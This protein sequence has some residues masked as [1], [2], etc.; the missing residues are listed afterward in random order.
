MG[1]VYKAQDL[2][3]HRT[4]ALKLLPSDLHA[5]ERAR[6]L[7]LQEA[8]S[9]SA[10]DH[11]NIGTIHAIE[12]AA[13]GSLF[14]VMAYYDGET[15]AARIASGP[16]PAAQ[17]VE[18]AIQ[19]A[20]G[21]AEAHAHN[22]VHRD[23]K[24]GNA[25][26]TRQGLT[27][28][29][30]FGLARVIES[31]ESTVSASISGT[32]AYMSP[33]QAQGKALDHRT[34]LWSLGVVLYEMLTGRL[35]FKGETLPARLYSIVHSAPAA[36]DEAPLE[37]QAIVYRALAKD[38]A[39]RYPTAKEM[40][41]DLE[42]AGAAASVLPA[43][44]RAPDNLRRY[45]ASASGSALAASQ[46]PRPFAWRWMALVAVTLL[47]AFGVVL[48]AFRDRAFT[49]LF[50][51]AA[52]HIAVLPLT[53][54][55]G[56]APNAAIADGLMESLTSKLSNLDVGSRSLWVVPASEVRR[57]RVED[58]AAARREFGAT[59]V[60][61]GS[62]QRQENALRLIVNLIDT[63]NMRQMGSA[64]VADRTGDYS[65]L[66]DLAVTR[67]ASLMNITVT[68][69]MM[70]SAGGSATPAAY[71]SYLKGL[72]FLQR[73][74]KPG[75]LDQAA[76]ALESAT[77]TDPQFAL[78]FA[79]L[80]EALLLKF[81]TDQNP[82]WLDQA[83]AACRRA[84][85]LNG[86]L[87][88]VHVI[89]GRVDNA[90]GHNDLA[91][92]EF[93]RALDLNP[94]SVE[95]LTGQGRVYEAQGRPAPAEATYRRATVLRP[96]YWDGYNTLGGFYLR[97]RRFADATAQFQKV[98]DL[99]PDNANAYL[100]LGAALLNDRKLPEAIQALQRSLRIAPSYGAYTNLG[101][102]YYRQQQWQEAAKN[103]EQAVKLN[104]NDFRP[105]LNLAAAYR[106]LQ[107][108]DQAKLASARGLP[109]LEGMAKNKPQDAVLQSALGLEYAHTGERGKA[110]SSLEAAA[111]I[112]PQ[113][114][115]ILERVGEGY[116]AL[117]DRS[118]AVASINRALANGY[119]L[120]N[121]KRDPDMRGIL[122]DPRFKP[123]S[124]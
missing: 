8:R 115:S 96:D 6:E 100:N 67:L 118:R 19:M 78:A 97:A 33:E 124:K 1:V 18:I 58:A 60:V 23:I 59:L 48:L 99:T 40:L 7:F 57:R 116:E 30:D 92:E 36:M 9:A 50:A 93:Q 27:K 101:N 46:A 29:V 104:G 2:K 81:Q 98:I 70:A 64:E 47:I 12:E 110:V 119:S 38:P 114:A 52:K 107:R 77:S 15:L 62:L 123:P 3:L 41:E 37:L 25:I 91:L 103:Y 66:E 22:I 68:R 55:G 122:A 105:W 71:E 108:P 111:A 14:I 39:E 11:P 44:A 17:A 75:N 95:A 121:L 83:G 63:K 112:A 21:L 117:G 113:D 24:P 87:A 120:D 43:G 76:S 82:R 73:Y 56:D 34:D 35:P 61:N 26:L 51:P 79:G 28:I 86:E 106:S 31:A 42:R 84:A 53:T 10:L 45:M 89:L 85:E 74:D 13:D 20:R 88:P 5:P 32:A 109:L 69:E 94:R 102:I 72:G 80:G 49:G 54:I 65:A 4:V 16:L 90:Q